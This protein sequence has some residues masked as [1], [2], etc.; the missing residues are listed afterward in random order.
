MR[1]ND[2]DFHFGVNFNVS[3]DSVFKQRNVEQGAPYPPVSGD[4]D[5]LD[6]TDFLLLDSSKFSLL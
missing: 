4:F 3:T 5:L 2:K 6:G 1:S